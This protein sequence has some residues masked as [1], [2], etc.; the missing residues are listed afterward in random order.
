MAIYDPDPDL[1][2]LFPNLKRGNYK[3]TSLVDKKY[4]CIAWAAENNTKFWWP[5]KM[6]V[7]YWPSGVSRKETL[8]AFVQLYEK[9]G[10]KICNHHNF[11]KGFEKIAIFINQAGTPTHATR[12]LSSGKWTSKLGVHKDI[13]H[14][15]EDVVGQEYGRIGV[16]LKKVTKQH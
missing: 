1:E 6:L 4:N 9:M 2:A 13:E 7:G 8:E 11:E 5:D 10:Y 14:S 12:Q 15:L 16:I 3:V